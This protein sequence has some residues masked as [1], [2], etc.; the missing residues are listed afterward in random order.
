MRHP[1]SDPSD[2]H[3][4]YHR[5]SERI[6]VLQGVTSTSRRGISSRSWDRRARARRRC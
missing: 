4:V 3:K 1:G 2:L 6:D 5:G